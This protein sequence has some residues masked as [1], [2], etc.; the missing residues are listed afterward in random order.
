MI[1]RCLHRIL[2]FVLMVSIFIIPLTCCSKASKYQ[3]PNGDISIIIPNGPG[4]GNDL[5]VNA[6]IPGLKKKLKTNVIMENKL[7]L[8]GM[9]AF[10]EVS[11]A[12]PDGQKLYFS[13]QTI[14]LL[15][16]AGYL[17]ADVSKMVPVAQVAEDAAAIYVRADSKWNNLKDLISYIKSDKQKLRIAS[18]GI[19]G[20]WHLAGVIF[21]R[22]LNADFHYVSYPTGSYPMLM[23]LLT[24]EVDISINGPSEARA[25]QKDGQ[26]KALAVIS[27]KRYPTIPDVPTC[28]EQ[29]LDLEFPV[30]RG[31]FT[32]AGTSEEVLKQLSDAVK[33][34]TQSEE[35]VK[36][37]KIGMPAAF[38]D[39][40][41]FDRFVKSEKE[42]Y[43]RIMSGIIESIK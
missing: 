20:V 8:S 18:N 34:A 26:I 11:G 33:E 13:S 25:F 19:G 1:M 24:G 12:K 31:L 4:G 10:K 43:D 35:F 39:Y 5:T 30:W 9:S 37:S 23:A 3:F 16:H 14:L 7:A 27:D 17:E 22:S 41:E 40:K 15:K 42:K 2:L 29:G 36:Y 38:R 28:K 32:T 21:A 6:L